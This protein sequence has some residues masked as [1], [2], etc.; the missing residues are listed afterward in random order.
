[1]S[2]DK[3]ILKQQYQKVKRLGDRLALIKQQIDWRPLIPL[4]KSVFYDNRITGGYPNTDGLIVVRSMLLQA[5]YKI[6]DT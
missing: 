2:F 1:M 4:M 5:W 3:F 6:S